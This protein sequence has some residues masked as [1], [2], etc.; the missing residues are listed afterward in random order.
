[1]AMFTAFDVSFFREEMIMEQEVTRITSFSINH[2]V[3]LPGLYVSRVDG[4]VTTYDM[5]TR[6]PN[7]GDL[8][9]NSTMHS[10]E[11]MFATY[12]RNGDLKD[13]VV[14]FGPMGCQTGF[15]LLVRNAD[16]AEVLRQVRLT[17]IK[18]LAHEGPVFGASS[19]ECGNYRNLSLA[20]A[21]TEAKRYLSE[22]DARPVT[23]QYKE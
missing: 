1:M 22:L 16:N 12:I 19:R 10:L 21:K 8:M 14:Y 15:Y 20:A 4:D 17:L 2:D 18:I 6:R 7:T 23:F 13:S 9:D 3:L 5:R 11:H